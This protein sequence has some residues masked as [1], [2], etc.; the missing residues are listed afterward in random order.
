MKTSI[1]ILFISIF[2]LN[3]AYSQDPFVIKVKTDNAGTSGN[4]EFT[5]P[6]N[7]G[8]YNYDIDLNNDGTY[9]HT[10]ITGDFTVNFGAAGVY[11]IAISGTFPAIFFNNAGD[12]L[13][14]M[15]IKQW[16]DISWGSFYRAFRGCENM[17]LT[18]ADAPD[19]LGVTS[20]ESMF[21]DCFSFNSS[22]DHWDVSNVTVIDRIFQ[23]ASSFNQPL[24]SW[25]VTNVVRMAFAFSGTT[26]F[27]QPL[28][29]WNVVG[30]T[31]LRETFRNSAFNQNLGDWHISSASRMDQIFNGSDLSLDNYDATLIGWTEA[32]KSIQA[33]VNLGANSVG[34]CASESA[35]SELIANSWT[36]D[37]LGKLCE[38]SKAFV[39][40]IQ[41]SSIT[42]N[43]FT[44]KTSSDWP[45]STYNFSVDWGDGNTDS[46]INGDVTHLF[47][48][49]G[50]Y[51]IKITGLFPT[52]HQLGS[53]GTTKVI[54]IHQFGDQAW[55]DWEEAFKDCEIMT[56][57]D[58]IDTPNLSSCTTL[59][60]AF[61]RARAFNYDIGEW[62]V[63]NIQRFDRMLNGASSFN[64]NLGKWNLKSATRIQD[65][66]IGSA[67]DVCNYDSTLIGWANNVETATGRTLSGRNR[68]Y[69]ASEDARLELINNKGWTIT[70]D[71]NGCIAIDNVTPTNPLCHGANNGQIAI[72]VSGGNGGNFVYSISPSS[73]SAITKASNL[74]TFSGLPA[75]DYTVT[76]QSEDGCLEATSSVVTLT[77]PDPIDLI[78][79]GELLLCNGDSDG[80]ITGTISGGTA[81][82][83]LTLVET[84]TTVTVNTDGGSYDFANLSAGS[85]NVNVTDANGTTGGCT[86]TGSANITEP[87]AISIS[88]E[89]S[90]N[91]SCNAASDGTITVEATGGT[92]DLTYT[93]G[94]TSNNTGIFTGLSAGTYNVEVTDENS[95]GP[96]VSNNIII[97]EPPVITLAIN[98]ETLLCN[99]DSD[100]NITGT[101]SGGIAPYDLTLVETGATQRVISDGGNYNFGNLTAGTYTI[102]ITA[103]SGT[104]AGCTTVSASI[105]EP[106]GLSLIANGEELKCSGDGDGN[107]TGTVSGGTAPYTITLVETGATQSVT[108]DGDSYDFSGLSAGSYTITAGDQGACSPIS[109]TVNIIEPTAIKMELSA[110][111]LSC[112][113]NTDGSIKGTITGGTAPY[114]LIILET[115]ATQSVNGI[116]GSF[117]F[118]GL[119]A[120]TYTVSVSD[121]NGCTTS[122]SIDITQPNAVTFTL[123]AETLICHGNNDGTIKGIISGGTSPYEITLAD[124][125]GMTLSAKI[126]SSEGGTYEFDGLGAG[127]YT[128]S[129]KGNNSCEVVSQSGSVSQPEPLSIEILGQDLSCKGLEDGKIS[130][131]VSGGVAPHIVSIIHEGN[132]ESL[133]SLARGRE[134]DIEDLEAG[135]YVIS[136]RDAN[137]C[138][139]LSDSIAISR[140]NVGTIAGVDYS[141]LSCFEEND[142]TITI[143]TE[144]DS[145][146]FSIDGGLTWSNSGLFNELAAGI[147]TLEARTFKEQ[148]PLDFGSI[149]KEIELSQPEPLTIASTIQGTSGNNNRDG[150]IMVE[151][152]GGTSPYDLTWSNDEKGS[153]ITNLPVGEYGLTILDDKGCT[154]QDSIELGV[155]SRLESLKISNALS[156]NGDGINDQWT[157]G[158]LE[159]FSSNEVIVFNRRGRVVFREVNYRNDWDGTTS[160]GRLPNGTYFYQVTLE[161]E[162]KRSGFFDIR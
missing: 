144:V 120:G 116:D 150:S 32:P 90:T 137:N 149:E 82:Y 102:S 145:V 12:R 70:E 119:Q 35:R 96:V 41:I 99:G 127:S 88:N 103:A 3:A 132:T 33:N 147:Y 160:L 94:A 42:D 48:A 112:N 29:D 158:S 38:A 125:I 67:L 86:A 105:I 109:Q 52:I 28:N 58:T 24:N 25:D 131:V 123:V 110:N 31:D 44:I 50:T 141:N 101:I 100:G 153:T 55:R 34:F 43:H 143:T 4:T 8:T 97:D 126:V 64:Q 59:F 46:G 69:C 15:E 159:E 151:V 10:G 11:D 115:G 111:V 108:N 114:S 14:L 20:L 162:F 130:G 45:A 140:P 85:Y 65:M 81:P 138:T 91:I 18:A 155:Q 98:G 63:S 146:E 17:T 19:L 49:V 47:T 74:H 76:V 5:I 89:A 117:D 106:A 80:N 6:T 27:N 139:I 57:A 148:C 62:D 72:E 21:Q 51:Q 152:S 61:N 157:I 37:D 95:C 121:T 53:S 161:G 2:S 1:L 135:I 92:G 75:G 78:V 54:T 87:A 23:R 136:V 93:L 124:S 154:L 156:P 13:K 30:V 68:Y 129:V 66:L 56:F 122:S 9:E 39:F 113:G 142:G 83:D 104:T 118:G 128:V 71:A 26:A 36:I 133:D 7:P 107:I 79:N 60:A 73:S 134:F 22:I 84:G 77:E 16:G 40:S